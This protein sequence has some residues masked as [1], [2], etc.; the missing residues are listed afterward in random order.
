M[1]NSPEEL[2]MLLVSVS[3]RPPSCMRQYTVAG[4]PWHSTRSDQ[5]DVCTWLSSY[6]G[7]NSNVRLYVL[8][9]K[10]N[11]FSAPCALVTRSFTSLVS[12]VS[13]S[14]NSKV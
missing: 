12:A 13:K 6:A 2:W 9:L 5:R 1:T 8:M 3:V 7:S 4:T 14:P 11:T 10:V